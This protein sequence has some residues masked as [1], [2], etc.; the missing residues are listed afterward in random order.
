MQCLKCKYP[1]SRVV[2][3]DYIEHKNIIQRRR[4][5]LRCSGRFTTQ[6]RMRDSNPL[7]VDSPFIGINK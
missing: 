3:T 5:C 4:E 1:D 6:E 2:S 7:M